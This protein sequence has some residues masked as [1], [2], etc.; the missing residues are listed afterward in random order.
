MKQTDKLTAALALGSIKRA[1][2][3]PA[4]AKHMLPAAVRPMRQAAGHVIEEGLAP[5]A[6]Q[7][8][9][10]WWQRMMNSGKDFYHKNPGY[11]VGAGAGALSGA[12]GLLGMHQGEQ[13]GF[14]RGQQDMFNRYQQNSH[15]FGGTM[16]GLGNSLGLVPDQRMFGFQ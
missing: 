5:A 1:N 3:L 12:L 14:T 7:T 16:R 4:V 8:A 13:Y 2:M 11:V 15:G 10:S 9:K 6:Q